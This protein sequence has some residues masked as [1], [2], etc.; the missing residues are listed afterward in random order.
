MLGRIVRLLKIKRK[1]ILLRRNAVF[2]GNDYLIG[3]A[4]GIS[5]KDGS[6]REN[7]RIGDHVCFYGNLNSQA[8]GKITIGDYCRI[9]IKTKINAVESIQIGNYVTMADNIIITDNN[10]HPIS[11]EFRKFMRMKLDKA[12][13]NLWRHSVHSPVIIRDNVWIGTNV[14]IHKGVEVG[15]NSII[16]AGS[17]VTKDV[18]SNCIAAGNPAKIVKT[19][20]DDINA[21]LTC[22]SYN[23]FIQ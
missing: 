9:G 2:L 20:I 19:N 4:A 11:P 15:E 10:N 18:P 12:G 23:E 1:I 16:A 6:V 7:I 3:L 13:T 14:R 8:G 17:I 5:L 22:Q 21:P